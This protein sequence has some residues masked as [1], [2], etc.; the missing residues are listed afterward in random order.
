MLATGIIAKQ[1]PTVV[2]NYIGLFVGFSQSDLNQC[3]T[4]KQFQT[5]FLNWMKHTFVSIDAKWHKN[6]FFDFLRR[7]QH[8]I[9]K[10]SGSFGS[11]VYLN[12]LSFSQLTHLHLSDVSTEFLTKNQF[13]NLKHLKLDHC[14]VTKTISEFDLISLW[15]D[16]E[17]NTNDMV[18]L[19]LPTLR[20]LHLKNLVQPNFSI[21]G[22]NLLTYIQ[23]THPNR[24]EVV[25][26]VYP[27]LEIELDVNHWHEKWDAKLKEWDRINEKNQCT[28]MTSRN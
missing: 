16:D 27:N 14:M 18:L 4:S 24:L 3:A 13:P 26:D 28:E 5:C 20:F 12:G 17:T 21:E 7:Y 1:Y 9:H 8:I 10:L 22:S 11:S 23:S 25:R 2:W 19:H 6:G 15:I